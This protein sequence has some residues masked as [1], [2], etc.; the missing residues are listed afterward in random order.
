MGGLK[1]IIFSIKKTIKGNNR[2]STVRILFNYGF[3]VHKQYI[4]KLLEELTKASRSFLNWR[5]IMDHKILYDTFSFQ[6]NCKHDIWLSAYWLSYLIDNSI[7]AFHQHINHF[8]NYRKLLRA[9]T[10][11]YISYTRILL[12]PYQVHRATIHST[13]KIKGFRQVEIKYKQ[14]FEIVRLK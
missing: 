10:A 2:L 11:I 3:V 9:K 1:I 5:E 12:I 7:H 14:S 13:Q 4:N 6:K 8:L